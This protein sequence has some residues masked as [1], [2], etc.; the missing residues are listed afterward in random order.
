[1]GP[2][3]AASPQVKGSQGAGKVDEALDRTKGPAEAEDKGKAPAKPN[4]PARKGGKGR[5]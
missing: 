1:V 5:R 3:G 4:L 2:L